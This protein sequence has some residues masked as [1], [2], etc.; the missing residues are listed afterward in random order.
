MLYFND[1]YYPYRFSGNIKLKG[2]V[3]LG[4]EGGKHPNE[5][6]LLVKYF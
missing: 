3:L 5:L 2:L 6:R 4:G 1:N